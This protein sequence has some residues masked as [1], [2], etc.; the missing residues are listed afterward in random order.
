MCVFAR[1]EEGH[2]R[3]AFLRQLERLLFASTVKEWSVP[4]RTPSAPE[5]LGILD[6]I[7]EEM[8]ARVRHFNTVGKLLE[9]PARLML[10]V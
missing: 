7:K 9:D 2:G 4:G 8:I 3:R 5:M 6:R 1:G 10:E